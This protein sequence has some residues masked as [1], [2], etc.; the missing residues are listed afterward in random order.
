MVF[1]GES[2]MLSA[3]MAC[4]DTWMADLPASEI[5]MTHGDRTFP[6]FGL[7]Q[8]Y[9]L[10]PHENK[11]VFKM[12]MYGLKELYLTYPDKKWY[13]IVGSDT[14]INVD[15][16]LNMLAE[17][18][19]SKSHWFTPAAPIDWPLEHI[20]RTIKPSSPMWDEWPAGKKLLNESFQWASGGPG[21]WMTNSVVKAYAEN[22]DRFLALDPSI[23]CDRCPDVSTGF[24][25]S[26]LNYELTLTGNNFRQGDSNDIA[27]EVAYTVPGAAK[28]PELPLQHYV[29]PRNMIAAAQH[30]KH[31]VCLSLV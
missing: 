25:L 18:D 23:S 14:Y 6:V 8:K 5:F 3:A 11:N 30:A 20:F 27:F 31:Q 19:E 13:N 10:S 26:L 15:Y 9:N 21:W 24:L 4:R 1:S 16:T 12:Q 22:I 7:N 28:V 29:G 17:F 2:I